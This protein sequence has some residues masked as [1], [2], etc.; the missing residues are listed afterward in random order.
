ME[1]FGGLAYNREGKSGRIRKQRF[2]KGVLLGSLVESWIWDVLTVCY[3]VPYVCIHVWCLK[4]GRTP[5]LMKR[6]LNSI[7]RVTKARREGD[8]FTTV[9]AVLF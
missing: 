1:K 6:V 5:S 8:D 7:L 4:C 9:K 2:R 3:I